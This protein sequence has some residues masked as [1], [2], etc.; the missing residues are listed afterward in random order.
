M[1]DKLKA[2]RTKIFDRWNTFVSGRG[3]WND[4]YTS[5]LNYAL[6][7]IDDVIREEERRAEYKPTR[8]K[9]QSLKDYKGWEMDKWGKHEPNK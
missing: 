9:D 3:D 8:E 6:G 7:L 2:T 5:G 1:L 4:G